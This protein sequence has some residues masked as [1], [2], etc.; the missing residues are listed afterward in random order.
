MIYACYPTTFFQL[1][2]YNCGASLTASIEEFGTETEEILFGLP[3]ATN[4]IKKK[5][6]LHSDVSALSQLQKKTPE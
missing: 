1:G 3:T 5:A 2:V 6:K 4:V